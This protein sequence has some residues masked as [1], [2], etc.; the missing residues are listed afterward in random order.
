MK[1]ILA[2]Q[3]IV[4]AGLGDSM[5]RIG[6][7]KGKAMHLAEYM[8]ATL[9]TRGFSFY[10]V[11]PTLTNGAP[12][13]SASDSDWIARTSWTLAPNDSLLF[14][15]WDGS[16]IL[17]NQCTVYFKQ[18]SGA[19]SLTVL[20]SGTTNLSLGTFSADAATAG[21]ATNY[22][23]VSDNCGVILTNASAA[24]VKVFG[25]ALRDTNN[26]GVELALLSYPGIAATDADD[27]ATNI[28][29]PILQTVAPDL[30]V[31]DWGE[32][33]TNGLS[34]AYTTLR[35]MFTS[36]N[37]WIYMSPSVGSGDF[38]PEQAQITM[39]LASA[40]KSAWA[41]CQR[42]LADTNILNTL[43]WA[44]D[45]T[46]L[47]NPAQ[48]YAAL[49]MA[50]D[51]GITALLRLSVSNVFSIT[52][53]NGFY[54][55]QIGLGTNNPQGQVHIFGTLASDNTPLILGGVGAGRLGM[56][57]APPN[58]VDSIINFQSQTVMGRDADD[59]VFK[60]AVGTLGGVGT[61]GGA[62]TRLLIS[63]NS[64]I[65][66]NATFAISGTNAIYGNGAGLT[67]VGGVK[68]YAAMVSF[69]N[70]TTNPVVTLFENSLPGTTGWTMGA[71][72]V[73]KLTNSAGAFTASKTRV[74][75]ADLQYNGY[76]L[77]FTDTNT[78]TFD[79]GG[80]SGV[81]FSNGDVEV[82]VYP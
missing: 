63:T 18:D 34:A 56:L 70:A 31:N 54:L 9:G 80:G 68:V 77:N 21:A 67:N 78:I 25:V 2:S 27:A 45:P 55:K 64:V 37:D 11:Q 5:I 1:R 29:M 66:T 73:Y 28:V 50:D 43:G 19:G 32:S 58:T 35:S 30:V 44:N 14:K 59:N 49:R 40:N 60:I 69:D 57:I 6:A 4:V 42:Y 22:G 75:C 81:A 24:N 12:T 16:N 72:G 8:A 82:R 51:F 36:S 20:K 23:F 46:H 3:G 79:G 13:F 39:R 47:S 10:A 61:I 52:R 33:T 74:I 38:L 65:V 62:T 7:T 17:A 41:D 48:Q 26:I 71:A 76:G 53:S 15:R